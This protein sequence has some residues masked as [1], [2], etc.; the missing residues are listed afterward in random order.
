MVHA[1]STV[2][3][4]VVALSAAST[5]AAPHRA[6]AANYL[7]A[8]N[9]EDL[10]AERGL[11][12]FLKPKASAKATPS[13]SAPAAASG[14]PKDTSSSAS[15]A[16]SSASGASSST[17]GA[18]SSASGTSS[19][20]SGALPTVTRHLRAKPTACK[21]SEKPSWDKVHNAPIHRTGK[22]SSHSSSGSHAKE[23]A[24]SNAAAPKQPIAARAAQPAHTSSSA[25]S[26]SA[27]STSA[28]SSTSATTTPASST[29]GTSAT[30]TPAPTPGTGTGPKAPGKVIGT[31]TTKG[32]DGKKT[33]VHILPPTRT[34]C[35]ATTPTGA[36]SST[37]KP[38]GH[39]QKEHE[40]QKPLTGAGA[41]PEQA[42]ESPNEQAQVVARAFDLIAEYINQLD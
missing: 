2:A 28:P 8:R 21:A 12:D 14:T 36:T 30:I 42:A 23:E 16:S 32:K 38:S 20:T 7:E 3:I 15:G 22:S 37:T 39:Q 26:T 10:L 33:V 17:V 34:R 19:S 11:F 41:K 27:S 9:Y 29:S 18:S 6:A 31:R 35:F 1:P 5:L 4:A 40:Q 24:S 13:A 25:A